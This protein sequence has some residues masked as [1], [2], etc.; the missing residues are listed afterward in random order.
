MV[1]REIH[2]V[3]GVGLGTMGAGIAEVVARTGLTV[4]GVEVNEL[5]IARARE[6]LEHSTERAVAGGKLDAAERAALLGR[7]TFTTDL[8]GLADVDLVVEAIPESLEL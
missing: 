8:K 3:G 7:I 6:H 4:V 1:A 5:C 2:S